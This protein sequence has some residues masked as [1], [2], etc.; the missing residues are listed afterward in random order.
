M[1]STRRA[2]PAID[3]RPR[4][5]GT[6]GYEHRLGTKPSCTAPGL[7]TMRG[8]TSTTRKRVAQGRNRHKS[9]TRLRFV[10]V[11]GSNLALSS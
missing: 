3:S 8:N 1:Q 4:F 11:N 2:V 7:K 5:R 6:A 9:F 10:L